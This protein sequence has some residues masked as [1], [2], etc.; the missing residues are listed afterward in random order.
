MLRADAIIGN[1]KGNALELHDNQTYTTRYAFISPSSSPIK[2]I[3]RESP[4]WHN[5]YYIE[6]TFGCIYRKKTGGLIK[7]GL[8]KINISLK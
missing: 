1:F 7:L 8:K 3:Y 4:Y 2:K 6:K 5:N